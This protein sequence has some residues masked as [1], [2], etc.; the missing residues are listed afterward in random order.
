MREISSTG[1]KRRGSS[2]VFDRVTLGPLITSGCMVSLREALG[3]INKWPANPPCLERT[4]LVCGIETSIDI[5]SPQEVEEFL[6]GKIRPFIQEFQSRW[7]QCGLVF[8]FSSSEHS[9]R[10]TAADEDVTWLRHDRKK[11]F[12]SRW[13]WNGSSTLNLARIVRFDEKKNPTIVGYHVPRIS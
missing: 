8:G 7:D 12:L 10:E 5:L 13:M 6:R 3:W 1:W 4:L 11:I 2:I 9:F